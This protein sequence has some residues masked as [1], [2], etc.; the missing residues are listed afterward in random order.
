M[1]DETDEEY[2]YS[3]PIAGRAPYGAALKKKGACSSK[4]FS[5]YVLSTLSP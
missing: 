5:C 4:L 2:E 1:S 3:V